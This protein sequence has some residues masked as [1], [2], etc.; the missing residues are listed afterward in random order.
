[1]CLFQRE[2]VGVLV[3][4]CPSAETTNGQRCTQTCGNSRSD[5]GSSLGSFCHTFFSFIWTIVSILVV[6]MNGSHLFTPDSPNPLKTRSKRCV[7]RPLQTP[8]TLSKDP[9]MCS[10]E[11]V[12]THKRTRSQHYVLLFINHIT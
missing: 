3:I 8:Q 4:L 7:C 11:N 1:M 12:E 5:A 9:T 10:Y 2:A 6:F